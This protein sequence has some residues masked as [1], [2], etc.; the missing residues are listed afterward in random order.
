MDVPAPGII[1]DDLRWSADEVTER[2]GRLAAGLRHAGVEPGDVVA[3][4]LPPCPQAVLAYHAAW[5][6]GAI[7]API[8]HRLSAAE[9]D[10]L[11]D[12]LAPAIVLDDP[13]AVDQAAGS[14]PVEPVQ[15]APDDLAVLLATSGSSGAPKLVRHTHGRLAY[16]AHLMARVHGLGPG[17]VNVMPSPF[18]HIS[19]LLNGVLVPGAASM[20]CVLMERWSAARALQACEAERVTFLSGPPTYFVQLMALPDF[21]PDRVASLRLVS[22]GGAG[23]TAAFARRAAQTLGAVVKRTYGSTEAPTVTTSYPGDPVEAGWQTDGRATG[24]VQLHVDEVTGELSV[25]GPE[26]FVGYGRDVGTGQPA[27]GLDADGWFATGDRARLDDGWLTV[28]G[29]LRDTIIRGGEN[30]DPAEVEAICARLPGV[31]EAVVVGY[32]D[33]EMGERVALVAVADDQPAADAVRRHCE[34]AGLARFKTP[35]RVLCLPELPTLTIGKPD[36]A[37]IRAIVSKGAG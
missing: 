37:A 17:D 20:S 23:V 3:F 35:E 12:R 16:K 4:R 19:G 1:T 11:V 9:V 33:E 31:R 10:A 21:V 6:L 26:L 15:P 27:A 36:R 13:A 14:R 2:S 34:A 5:M 8:H 18:A 25:R 22:C 29:R 30:V 24:P 7:A 32:P 28:L